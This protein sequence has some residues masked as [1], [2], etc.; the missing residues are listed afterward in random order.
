MRILV[1][2]GAGYIG[3]HTLLAVLAAGHEAHVL[4]NFS[5]SH[6]EALDRVRR[7]SNREFGV[8][9]ADLRDK[10]AMAAAVAEARPEAVIHFAGLKAVGESV[11]RPLAYF[12]NNVG[13]TV[14]LLE[15]LQ[16]SGCRRFVFSSSAT[17]YGDPDYLPIDESHPR[18][19]T[20][21][22]GRTKLQIEEMLEDLAVSDP[23]WS[24][25]LLRYFN[26]VGAHPS[27]RIGE[28][29]AGIPNNLMPFIAQVAVGRRPHLNVFGDDYGTPDGTGVRDYIHVTDLARAH[30]AAV[31]WAAADGTAADGTAAGA[32]GGAP[33][34]EGRGCT[35]FNLGTGRGTSVK[36]MVAAFAEAAGRPVPTVIAPRRAGDI[37]ACW[38]DPGKAEAALGW[39]A[40]LD[41]AAM[42]RSTW[43]WQSQNPQGYRDA[44]AAAG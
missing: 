29:P 43:A 12:D 10:A 1:T 39:R 14:A 36:E 6:P 38:A 20:N 44:D 37:A 40:E 11:A 41:L 26:P 9:R 27:G 13:G 25:A 7:L 4:D 2:G 8:T 18:R 33:R 35:A 21:P 24:I 22:Y 30:L 3:S 17:V 28:D 42:C 15:A 32:A 19:A 31:D 16:A 23:A 34:G 5:N